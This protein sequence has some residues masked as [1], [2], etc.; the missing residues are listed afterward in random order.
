[1][2]LICDNTIRGCGDDEAI[3]ILR[4]GLNLVRPG[5]IRVTQSELWRAHSQIAS[6]RLY[7]EIEG[8][9][10]AAIL[11]D[12]LGRK[13]RAPLGL[14]RYSVSMAACQLVYANRLGESSLALAMA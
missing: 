3:W 1:V 13:V 2:N 9:E 11:L 10:R 7:G 5:L 14:A 8:R 12:L 4:C 6:A